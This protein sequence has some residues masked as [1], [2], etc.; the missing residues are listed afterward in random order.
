[1]KEYKKYYF[2]LVGVVLIVFIAL[3]QLV[4]VKD[5]D[6]N[7]LKD[8]ISQVVNLEK[9]EQ[10]DSLK[11]RKLYYIDKNEV[12]EFILFAPKSN[13]DAEEVLVLKSGDEE[14]MINLKSKVEARIKKQSDSFRNYRP[15]EYDIISNS[16]L[17]VK[18][19]YLVL[20]IS[21]ESA[22]IEAAVNRA[23]K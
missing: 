22:E 21:K 6:M 7:E 9:V 13:M 14:N 10:G 12:E 11:L 15:E 2:A 19:N 20:I 3:Y 1:M 5:L 4:K 23:F 8:Q 17:K 16:V 18:G